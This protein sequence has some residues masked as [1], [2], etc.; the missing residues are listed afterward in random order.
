ML[1]PAHADRPVLLVGRTG[2]IGWELE[3]A[4]PP[5]GAIVALGRAELDLSNADAIRTRIRATAPCLIVN[6]AAYTAVDRAEQEPDLALSVNGAAPGVMA[7]EAER[8]GVPLVHYSTDYVFD[9]RSGRPYVEDDPPAP[10]NAYGRSKLAG[11]RAIL[12]ACSRHFIF[13]TSWVYA[14]RGANFL[15]TIRRLAAER[16]ELRVVDDQ[17][18]GPTWAR[19]VA[20]ATTLALGAIRSGAVALPKA[21]GIYH[22]SAAGS[23]TWC[24]FAKRI[25]ERDAAAGRGKAIP[26]LSIPTSEYPLPARRPAYSILDT[27]KFTSTFGLALP[28]WQVQLAL[29]MGD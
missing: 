5:L 28:D 26:V 21:S 8:L 11:E 19:A 16:S 6:A 12:A 2:Q 25:V 20:E 17:I 23:T 3:R 10:L 24:G 9:G 4:L 27:G 18:G 7:E 22:L 13:R 29:C 14:E 15:R 1:Q